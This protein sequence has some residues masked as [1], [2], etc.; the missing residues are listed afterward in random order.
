[1]TKPTD[2]SLME[3]LEPLVRDTVRDMRRKRRMPDHKGLDGEIVKGKLVAPDVLDR[4]R[5]IEAALKFLHAKEKLDPGGEDSEWSKGLGSYH[6]QREGGSDDAETRPN[7][8]GS[9]H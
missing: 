2:R 1:M 8:S 4:V 9:H 7:G 5:A 6:D 3:E